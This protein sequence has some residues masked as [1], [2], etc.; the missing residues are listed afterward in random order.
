VPVRAVTFDYWDTLYANTQDPARIAIRRTAVQQM[1]AAVGHHISEQDVA[2]LY[3][4]AGKEADRWWREE[5]RGYT[6]QERVRWM[7]QRLEVQRPEDCQYVARAVREID[8]AL[9][10][11]PPPLLLGAG[12][13]L[14]RLSS[15]FK[16]GVVSDTGFASGKA[17]DRVLERDQLLGMFAVTVYSMDVGHAKPRPEPFDAAVNALGVAPG[18]VVHV[19][20]DERT[21]IR[22]ALAAGLRAVRVDITRSSGPSVAEFVARSH[23]EL[24]EYL[25]AL[26]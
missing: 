4:A 10:T 18:D 12:D 14:A 24:A 11:Y 21:D 19:G 6:T 22:G 7:L 2:A 26:R 9:L 25:L 8:D 3:S 16:L 5:H 20:D 23:G 15:A 1:L 17:Q 13:A